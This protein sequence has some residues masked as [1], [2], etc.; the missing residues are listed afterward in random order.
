[1]DNSEQIVKELVSKINE[2]KSLYITTKVKLDSLTKENNELKNELNVNK[3]QSEKIENDYK[4]LKFV[5]NFAPNSEDKHGAKLKINQ[6][7]REI[8]KCIA[9][10]NK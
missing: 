9:L 8:D 10:L 5:K 1:M 2:L 4:I 3:F 6:I 7:V